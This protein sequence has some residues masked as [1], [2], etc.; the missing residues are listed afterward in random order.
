LRR[1]HAA[2]W[3]E[4]F[5]CDADGAGGGD[6]AGEVGDF[7]GGGESGPDF[8]LEGVEG[9]FVAAMGDRVH[10]VWVDLGGGGVLAGVL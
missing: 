1:D 7:V 9:D 6:G 4:T 3:P 10:G 8:V 2:G 5:V